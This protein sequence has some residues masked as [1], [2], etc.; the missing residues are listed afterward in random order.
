ML[1][2][3]RAARNDRDLAV[4]LADREFEAWF[5]ASLESL[6]GKRG[7]RA[8]AQ[9]TGDPEAV[10]DAKGAL[11]ALTERSIYSPTVDQAA[12]VSLMDLDQ[13]RTRSRSFDK[14]CR[15]LSRLLQSF[16]NDEEP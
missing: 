8:D 13:T 1:A 9:W 10:R 2:S 16:H 7:I 3:A 5:L 14:L 6:R 15:D 12:L 4:V 11:R